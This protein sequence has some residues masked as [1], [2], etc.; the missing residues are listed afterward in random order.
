M[1]AADIALAS[2]DIDEREEQLLSNMQRE[3]G[4][5]DATA[6]TIVEVL[7]FKYAK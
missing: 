5:D 3:L 1:L 2:G 6:H 7:G 4:I